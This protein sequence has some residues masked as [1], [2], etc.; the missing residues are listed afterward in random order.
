MRA[1]FL[2]I[3]VF[4]GLYAVLLLFLYLYQDRMVY[5]PETR[6]Y[7]TPDRMGL[8]FEPVKI[9]LKEGTVHGWF[10]PSDSGSPAVLFCH[11]NA[12]NIADRL[13]MLESIHAAGL[14]VLI[15]D[16]RGYGES[17]GTPSEP[18]MYQ[19][20]RAA[21]EWLSNRGFSDTDIIV[22][23]RSLGSAVAAHLA[24]ERTFRAV[25]LE[26]TFP[27]LADVAAVHFP[28]V[29]VR[30]IL[31]Y[32]YE[33]GKYLRKAASPVVVIQSRQDEVMPFKMGQALYEVAP[34]PRRFVAVSGSHNMYPPVD[35][36][37]VLDFAT[38]N[39]R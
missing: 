4:G 39:K 19:D 33:T 1:L 5:F 12:G 6:V 27:R 2:L 7:A 14:S 17:P 30:L 37:D 16:Y 24:Q 26:A 36:Q 34:E 38:Q 13:E 9:A 21:C 22:Y 11:G 32:K 23:G 15:F 35:W 10:V 8:A 29:P 28:W 25:V 18:A 3:L 20:A 31:K